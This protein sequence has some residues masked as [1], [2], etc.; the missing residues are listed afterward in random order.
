MRDPLIIASY[1]KTNKRIENLIGFSYKFVTMLATP[2][3]IILNISI[4]IYEYVTSDDGT[5]VLRLIFPML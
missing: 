5:S 1:T 2:S 3:F 4:S